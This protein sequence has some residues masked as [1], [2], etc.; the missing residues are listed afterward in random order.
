MD[1][2]IQRAIYCLYGVIAATFLETVQTVS[3]IYNAMSDPEI[4]ALTG[5]SGYTGIG[6]AVFWSALLIVSAYLI[7]PHLKA[8]SK[9]AWISAL[10]VFLVSVT[11]YAFPFSLLGLLFLL[12]RDVRTHFI[13]ELD[14]K[15]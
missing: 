14:I 6:P 3:I 15:I 2:K 13:K 7:I 5:Y 1:T 11:S 10:V 8:K 12:D 4:R 9:E